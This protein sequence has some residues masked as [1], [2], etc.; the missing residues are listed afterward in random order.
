MAKRKHEQEPKTPRGLRHLPI[1]PLVTSAKDQRTAPI[2]YA[3]HA[4]FAINANEIFMDFY[5]IGPNPADP[6]K[7]EAALI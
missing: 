1:K 5:I 3:N 7:P 2:V 4:Q 6:G